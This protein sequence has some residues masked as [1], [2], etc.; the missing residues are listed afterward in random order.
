MTHDIRS[1]WFQNLENWI[2]ITQ[3]PIYSKHDKCETNSNA[4]YLKLH[5]VTRI[6]TYNY[7]QTLDKCEESKF[8]K[9]HVV[10]FIA[11]LDKKNLH[12]E[13]LEFDIQ[14]GWRCRLTIGLRQHPL[15][16]F[17]ENNIKLLN[18]FAKIEAQK[19]V[20]SSTNFDMVIA[21][22]Y[23]YVKCKCRCFI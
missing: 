7:H 22:I 12:V 1:K 11:P 17:N 13:L 19:V 3:I 5:M 2:L 9:I 21:C 15:F 18:E 23:E 4:T 8:V 16:L 10:E 14:I 6:K 20:S